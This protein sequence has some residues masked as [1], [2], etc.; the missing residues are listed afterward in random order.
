MFGCVQTDRLERESGSLGEQRS[1]RTSSYVSNLGTVKYPQDRVV[2]P[3]M[4]FPFTSCTSYLP[5][6]AACPFST[7]QP[8]IPPPLL[9]TMDLLSTVR[10]SGSRGGVNFSWDEVTTSVHRENY[11]GHSLKAPV[12]RWQAGRDLNWYAKADD[13]SAAPG[14][15]DQERLER[16]RKEELRKIK[17][18]EEDALAR[19]LGLPVAQRDTS[20]ANAVAVGPSRNIGPSEPPADEDE[21]MKGGLQLTGGG[22]GGGEIRIGRGDNIDMNGPGGMTSGG[23]VEAEDEMEGGNI[24]EMETTMAILIAE[25]RIRD[26]TGGTEAAVWR[27]I[28]AGNSEEDGIGRGKERRGGIEAAVQ[29]GRV[30]GS[31]GVGI[32]T[33]YPTPM[34]EHERTGS[35]DAGVNTTRIEK[36]MSNDT[37]RRSLRT[38]NDA[39]HC[40]SEW[41]PLE[42]S[43]I[44]PITPVMT[45]FVQPRTPKLRDIETKPIFPPVG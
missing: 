24:G 35:E 32:R 13:S 21:P 30:G 1:R 14:E 12:G 25:K 17:E 36:S 9:L 40:N 5:I 37:Q 16:E 4:G 23:G 22:K 19:A 6:H 34:R 3:F 39:F 26:G 45:M 42:V 11:L 28:V 18:A 2:Q 41:Y 27:G 15:T 10:K 29:T 31:I 33:R 43:G 8:S 7:T 44:S 38:T 20:G